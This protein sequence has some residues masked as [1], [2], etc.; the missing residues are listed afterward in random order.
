MTEQTKTGTALAVAEPLSKGA[1]AALKPRLP[2][3]DEYREVVGPL[4]W[5]TLVDVVHPAASDP[6]VVLAALAY[7]RER[8]LDPMKRVVHIVPRY[9]AKSGR[10]KDTIMAAVGE[11]RMTAHR[12]GVFAGMD[13]TVFG[14]TIKK[15]FKDKVRKKDKQGDRWEEEVVE[16]EFPAWAK[17]TVY[18]MVGTQRVPFP[19]PRVSWL[20]I[21]QRKGR[22]TIPNERWATA[23]FDQLEKCAEA[24]ALRRAFPEEAPPM[25]T[26]EEGEYQGETIDLEATPEP[27]SKEAA[28]KP[29]RGRP[30]KSEADVNAEARQKNMAARDETPAHDP[31][32]GEIID[33][34]V[35]EPDGDDSETTQKRAE[36]DSTSAESGGELDRGLDAEPEAEEERVEIYDSIGE[37]AAEVVASDT[38]R[39]ANTISKLIDLAN[40]LT[41]L[42]AVAENNKAAVKI[43]DERRPKIAEELRGTYKARYIKLTGKK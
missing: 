35:V 20:S 29:Q 30:K 4:A 9:D 39:I 33:A 12:T 40:D 16:V 26:L 21:Y 43:L 3:L 15:I 28:P 32:T 10:V 37:V 1:I 17:V 36:N 34:E 22:S 11:L 5:K 42:K 38:D 13:E 14:E 19:G 6:S 18:R 7:C 2:Y 24:A 25:L 23:P 8:N 31:E 41:I 27:D